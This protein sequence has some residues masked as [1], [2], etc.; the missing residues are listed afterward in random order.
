MRS[1]VQKAA[2]I[3]GFAAM[4]LGG[5]AAPVEGDRAGE[6]ERRIV[7]DAGGLQRPAIAGDAALDH[8]IGADHAGDDRDVAMALAR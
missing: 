7:G 1:A 6:D 3:F 5:F 8:A 4:A 2:V